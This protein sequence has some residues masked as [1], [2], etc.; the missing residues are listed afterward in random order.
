MT[1]WHFGAPGGWP[2]A[3]DPCSFPGLQQREA[4]GWVGCRTGA[5]GRERKLGPSCLAASQRVKFA[6]GEVH[7]KS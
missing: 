5:R 3:E 4:E 6:K 2:L 7:L 1:G